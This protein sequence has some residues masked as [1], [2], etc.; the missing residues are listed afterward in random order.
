MKEMWVFDSL[1]LAAYGLAPLP[2]P[3]TTPRVN[4]GTPGGAK[5]G[6]VCGSYQEGHLLDVRTSIQIDPV[7]FIFLL[8]D[9]RPLFH[10]YTSVEITHC[11]NGATTDGEAYWMYYAKGSGVWYN[12]GRTAVFQ[13]HEEVDSAF[14]KLLGFNEE[15]IRGHCKGCF[16]EFATQLKQQSR[17]PYDSVQ[18]LR[19]S[20]QHCGNIAIEIVDFNVEGD[21]IVCHPRL[22]GGLLG[23]LECNCHADNY[24]CA[25]CSPA[26]VQHWWR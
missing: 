11:A 13:S 21:R 5:N 12:L 6:P 2:L 20:D 18:I 4:G 19:R 7:N 15:Y 25:R 10:D 8:H 1:F 9:S 22:T 3:R 23:E 24:N 14:G 16:I 26:K 17:M